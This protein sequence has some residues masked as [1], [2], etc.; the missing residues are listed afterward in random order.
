[1]AETSDTVRIL[2]VDD[3]ESMRGLIEDVLAL[4]GYQVLTAGS[5]SE[6]RTVIGTH[7]LDTIV[8]DVRMPD[9]SG[10]D[11][12]RDARKRQPALPAVVVTAY[13]GRDHVGI[14]EDL[15]VHSFITKPFTTQQLRYS[16]LGALQSVA[17]ADRRQLSEGIDARLR[18]TLG[19]VGV[20]DHIVSLRRQVRSAA[21]VELPI[22]IQ[23]P[24]GTGKDLVARA[25]HQCSSRRESAMVTVNC[26]AIPEHLQEAELFGHCRGAFTGAISAREGIIAAADGSVL[27]LDEVAELSLPTQA[28]LLRVLENGEYVRLGETRPRT[29]DIRVLSATNR[30]LGAM[31][32]AGTFREDLYYRLKGLVLETRALAT[33]REDIPALVRFY[34]ARHERAGSVRTITA[35]ALSMLV[36]MPW[37]GNVR[38]LRHAIELMAHKASGQKRLNRHIVEETIGPASAGLPDEDGYVAAKRRAMLEF[39]RRYFTQL[40]TM[41]EGNISRAAKRARM[42]RSNLS[43]RIHAL[44]LQPDSFRS[45]AS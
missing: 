34:L 39:D 41:H 4:E 26:A 31:V 20:S 25:I 7:C 10:I 42:D 6:A 8:T 18:G 22:L 40:L 32:D 5:V 15:G 9:G 24:S 43:K 12:I 21:R 29:A 19:L 3:E 13:P 33:H 28:K 16:V 45:S 30:D 35:E 14:A 1:M 38:E 11:V 2:V 17:P 27:F 23:G 36:R 37:P 44:R